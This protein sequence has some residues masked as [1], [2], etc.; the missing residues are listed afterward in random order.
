MTINWNEQITRH[1]AWW[2]VARTDHRSLAA[3]N[4]GD[5]EADESLRRDVVRFADELIE[6]IREKHKRLWHVNSWYRCRALNEAVGGNPDS[7]H[8]F[9]TAIDFVVPG[10]PLRQVFNEV[11]E[12][13]VRGSYYWD[14]LI[15]EPRDL[16]LTSDPARWIHLSALPARPGFGMGRRLS[17]AGPTPTASSGGGW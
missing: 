12:L 8:M 6:P 2:E 14:E 13:L 4:R 1:F 17:I 7:R 16:G 9:G 3:L 11:Y 5:L 15:L 10:V